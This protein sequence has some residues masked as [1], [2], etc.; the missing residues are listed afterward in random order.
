MRVLIAGFQMSRTNWRPYVAIG[1]VIATFC[2]ASYLAPMV[3]RL[4][5][6]QTNVATPRTAASQASDLAAQPQNQ[7]EYQP[8]CSKRS[9][10][11][12]CA[13]LR[14]AQAADS[15]SALNLLGVGLL[16]ATLLAT[17]AAG[18]LPALLGEQWKGLP[19]TNCAPTFL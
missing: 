18:S 12:L 13:Q 11:D 8:D 5:D 15:Q 3:A 17:G 6:S 1:G 2:F 16:G 10:A 19:S 14:M 4:A 7:M 9:D